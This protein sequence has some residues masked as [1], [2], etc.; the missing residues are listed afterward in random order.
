MS[1]NKKQVSKKEKKVAK[2]RKVR[3]KKEKE[4]LNE[5]EEKE[6]EWRPGGPRGVI[7]GIQRP[8]KRGT[9]RKGHGGTN[10][11]KVIMKVSCA[12]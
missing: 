8:R 9:E 6:E 7:I 2:E 10:G 5:L 1:L 3:V 12:K 4:V 11:K